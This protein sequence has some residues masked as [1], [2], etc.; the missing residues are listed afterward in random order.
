LQSSAEAAR[1]QGD[2]YP[3]EYLLIV[4]FGIDLHFG[5]GLSYLSPKLEK[6]ASGE[7]VVFR[8]ADDLV[9]GF[10]HRK[11]AERFLKE[12]RERLTSFALELHP[13]KTLLIEFGRFAQLSRQRRGEGKAETFTFLGFT[14][15]CARTPTAI[16]S[17][18]ARPN[19][20][21][22]ERHCTR[23]KRCFASGC[24]SGSTS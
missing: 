24:M 14:H 22:C 3:V 23:S 2:N 17:W 18:G 4:S 11:D 6:V 19:P 8:Y 13:E 21:G 7:V 12:F 15:Y 20:S 16:L 9:V 5:W 10:Q 1:D